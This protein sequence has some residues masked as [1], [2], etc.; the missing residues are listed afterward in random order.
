MPKGTILILILYFS[1]YLLLLLLFYDDVPRTKSYGLYISQFV[2]QENLVKS[3]TL[4][5]EIKFH[6]LPFF[7]RDAGVINYIK[8]F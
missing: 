2:F 3:V 8:R 5:I 6:L 7:S 1:S 4:P